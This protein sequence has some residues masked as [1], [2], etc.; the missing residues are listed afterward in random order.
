FAQ[1]TSWTITD[2]YIIKFSGTKAEGTFKGLSGTVLFNPNN[3]SES[4]FDVELDV[5]TI[6]TGNKTKDKHARG[7]SWFDVDQFPK[8][9]FVSSEIRNL[10]VGY[11]AIGQ[12]EI[13]GIKKEVALAFSFLDEGDKAM[14][15][16]ELTVN[17]EDYGI[18]GNLF[19]F[20]VGDEF[21][22]TIQLTANRQ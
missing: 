12:M 8:I 22:I 7:E 10:E 18:E 4:A 14:F 13:K 9:H 3:L 15:E 2:D 17:R 19:E 16:G 11:E 1:V 21:A 20:V 5:S 6:S